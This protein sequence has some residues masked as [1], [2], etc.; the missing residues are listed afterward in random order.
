MYKNRPAKYIGMGFLIIFAIFVFG[1]I[2]ML[3]WNWLVPTLFSGP[4]I[5]YWQAMGLLVLSKLLFSG[6][7]GRHHSRHH[8]RCQGDWKSNLRERIDID[9]PSVEPEADKEEAN[10]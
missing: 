2:T 5:T 4:M 1:S 8:R 9:P 3:L 7:S 6:S 10:S